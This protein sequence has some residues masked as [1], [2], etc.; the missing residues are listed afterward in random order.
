MEPRLNPPAACHQTG[1]GA[2]T[3]LLFLACRPPTTMPWVS[4]LFAEYKLDLRKSDLPRWRKP[5]KKDGH[6]EICGQVRGSLN[7]DFPL[8]AP[9]VLFGFQRRICGH[10]RPS[11]SPMALARGSRSTC[12]AP[13]SNQEK[14]GFAK[15]RGAGGLCR[16]AQNPGSFGYRSC[17][18]APHVSALL[19]T[20][21]RF[22]NDSSKD[23]PMALQS[24]FFNKRESL[25]SGLQ[26][27]G[28]SPNAVAPTLHL[29]AK[30]P[31][32]KPPTA[33][34]TKAA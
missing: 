4:S 18:C 32:T 7:P 8:G 33:N 21:S 2:S 25:P 34:S 6:R 16:V 12:T 28:M 3:A 10:F 30:P 24:P 15:L 27:V 9:S 13:A 14:T 5:C 31:T 20:I 11:S 19:P 23:A 22:I 17:V 29:I 1:L 26:T